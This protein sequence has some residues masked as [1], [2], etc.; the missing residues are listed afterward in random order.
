MLFGIPLSDSNIIR[1]FEIYN[2][3]L[4]LIT[5]Y[6][7]GRL[8][9]YL[10]FSNKG[11][12]LAFVGLFL[13]YSFF[14][15]MLYMPV[16]TDQSAFAFGMLLLYFYMTKNNIGLIIISIIGIFSGQIFIFGALILL[17]FP[18]KDISST[19]VPNNDIVSAPNNYNIIVSITIIIFAFIYIYYRHFIQG[20]VR[21]LDTGHLPI[22]EQFI[23]L[24]ISFLLAYLFIGLK[25]ILDSADLYVLK[26]WINKDNSKL[27]IVG[28]L[29]GLIF[30]VIVIITLAINT[31]LPGGVGRL[32]PK[33]IKFFDHFL[34]GS[35]SKPF[36]PVIPHVIYFGPFTI[37]TIYLW[38]QITNNIH[39]YGNGLTLFIAFHFILTTI[40]M[41][42]QIMNFFPFFVIFTVMAY[43]ELDLNKSYYWFIAIMSLLCSKVWLRLNFVGSE[44]SLM[45]TV[46]SKYLMS[47]G[48]YMNDAMYAIQG[49]IVIVTFILFYVIFS[50]KIFGVD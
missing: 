22:N 1:G 6:T 10:K 15:H 18:K 47:Y 46:T 11:K 38:K 8:T 5:A 44:P 7:L 3:I 25:F 17:I 2:L 49:S 42:R 19:S 13:N 36:Y 39:K 26:N 34:L 33:A 43:E 14:K 28:V 16:L 9:D 31:K 45:S 24:S 27:L 50:K 35:I 48:Y 29:L 37:L 12:W 30:S 32:I 23:Y 41:G 20:A 40:P 21:T 4:F